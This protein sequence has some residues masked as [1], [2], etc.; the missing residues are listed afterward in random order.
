MYLATQL[1]ARAIAIQIIASLISPSFK[2]R[3]KLKKIA[4]TNSITAS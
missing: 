3:L 2:I 1:I 4:I